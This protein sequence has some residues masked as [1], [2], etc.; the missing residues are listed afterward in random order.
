MLVGSDMSPEMVKYCQENYNVE[1]LTFEKLDVTKG[2]IFA[3]ENLGSFSLVTSFSCLHWVTDHVATAQLVNKI[4]KVGGKFL[5]MVLG[6]QN[7]KTSELI[8][9]EEMKNEDQWREFLQNVS[10]RILN[11]KQL[12]ELEY[13]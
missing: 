13:R 9:F 5:F 12:L 3:H 6:G 7:M 11:T 4:L 8:I 1:N 10:W 2:E